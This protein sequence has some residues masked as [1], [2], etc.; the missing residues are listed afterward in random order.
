MA[1]R[2]RL[3]GLAR[4]VA[5]GVPPAVREVGLALAARS[6]DGPAL[7]P[8]PPPGPVLVLAPHPDDETIGAGGAIAR[9]VDRGD[10]VTVLVA[11]SGEATRGG[12][13]RVPATREAECLAACEALGV[14]RPP[15][16]LRLPDGDLG[17]HVEALGRQL[18]AHGAEARVVYAPSVLD[19]HRDHR[20]ANVG[21]ARAGLDADVYGYEV[22]SPGPA[23]VLL[24]VGGVFGRK[25]RA[26]RCYAT[27][28]ETVDYVR[29]ATG[30]SA[31]RSGAAGLGGVGHVEGF[32]RLEPAEHAALVQRAGLL[33]DG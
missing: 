1:V 32:L 3:H 31:Y 20:A 28:L 33:T 13:D 8:G 12:G 6:S 25:Q 26:L 17:A 24:D 15:V 27:A 29:T 4:R 19:P 22:W 2:R 11:T 18:R 30:L 16:F 9:H 21:L 10:D 23:D 14:E 5:G 7:L